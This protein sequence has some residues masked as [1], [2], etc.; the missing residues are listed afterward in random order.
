MTSSDD[1]PNDAIAYAA[2]RIATFAESPLRDAFYFESYADLASVHSG[3]TELDD[4]LSFLLSNARTDKL[5]FISLKRI[6]AHLEL[7]QKPKPNELSLW[8][9]QY[10]QN[11]VTEPKSGRTGP[12][13]SQ[14]EDLFLLGL[15]S[16]LAR[17]LDKPVYPSVSTGNDGSVLQVL[18]LA[19]KEVKK[20]NRSTP[21]PMNPEAMKRRYI[22][23]KKMFEK[24]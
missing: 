16:T 20:Q 21:F 12:N 6:C 17:R 9:V 22:K 24:T 5:A 18:A 19:S 14:I 15:T 8:L 7:H 3:I 11:I 10:L 1:W 4:I 2:R 23:A 13:K